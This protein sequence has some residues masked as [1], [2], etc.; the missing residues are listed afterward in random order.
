MNVFTL[1]FVFAMMDASVNSPL[2]SVSN[3]LSGL[4]A[5]SLILLVPYPLYGASQSIVGPAS[6]MAGKSV[7]KAEKYLRSRQD[8]EKGWQ[9]QYQIR[10]TDRD[11]VYQ[12]QRLGHVDPEDDAFRPDGWEDRNTPDDSTDAYRGEFK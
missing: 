9:N 5:L 3:W 1:R 8:S 4:A 6:S 11:G 2:Q 7:S 10:A 12:L